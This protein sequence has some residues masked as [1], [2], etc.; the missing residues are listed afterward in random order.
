LAKKY[1]Q[2]LISAG[3]PVEKLIIFGSYAK[4]NYKYHSDLDICVVSPQFGKNRF[5]ERLKL[6]T[7]A[8]KID[9]MIEPHPYHPKDLQEKWDP[10]AEQIRTTGK[11]L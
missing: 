7:I 9:D 6:S 1:Y 2:E 8:R 5:N 10:L 4:G 11:T 3:I